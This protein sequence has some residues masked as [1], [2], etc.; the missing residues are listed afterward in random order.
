M[1]EKRTKRY[2]LNISERRRYLMREKALPAWATARRAGAQPGEPQ[3]SAAELLQEGAERTD[4]PAG[5]V[6]C[7]PCWLYSSCW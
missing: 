4:V 3:L 7:A 6:P 1:G 5:L 2:H